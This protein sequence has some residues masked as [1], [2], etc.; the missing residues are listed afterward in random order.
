ME[1]GVSI[2]FR[3]GFVTSLSLITQEW[4][5][6]S[7]ESSAKLQSIAE[8]GN[9]SVDM[10]FANIEF[11]SVLLIIVGIGGILF[12]AIKSR[13]L[14]SHSLG[15]LLE[16]TAETGIVPSRVSLINILGWLAIIAG[17]IAWLGPP[18][19]LD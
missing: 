15:E 8:T 12:S 7:Q 18:P 16:E 3:H 10:F 17:L 19:Y 6:T 14:A 1:S 5:H 2:P 13:Q 11:M 4:S 9:P